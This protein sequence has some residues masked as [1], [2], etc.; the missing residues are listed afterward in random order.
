MQVSAPKIEA[1]AIVSASG[2][3]L[4]SALP[5]EIEEDR[6][7]SMSATMLRLGERIAKDFGRGELEQVNIKGNNGF[8]ALSAIG[9][10][11]VLTALA[12]KDARPGLVFL[13][14]QRAAKIIND[15]VK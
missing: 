4:A 2:L 7:S 1:S 9:D 15:L 8:I 3:I 12:Q 5:A 13:E 6:V 11:A 10:E 14:M